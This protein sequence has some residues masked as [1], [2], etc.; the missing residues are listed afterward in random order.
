MFKA[1]DFRSIFGKVTHK[2]PAFRHSRLASNERVAGAS[3]GKLKFRASLC[4]HCNNALTQPHDRAWE[5]LSSVLRAHGPLR[6]GAALPL[7][8]AFGAGAMRSMLDVHLYFLKLLGCYAVE[9]NVPLPIPHFALCIRN[10]VAHPHIYL[11]FVAME[12][13][14][15]S[16]DA[17]VGNIQ[18]L[19]LGSRTVAASWF[20]LV[21]RLGVHVAYLEPGHPRFHEHRGWHPEQIGT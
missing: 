2:A 8:R 11:A 10:S 17:M 19:S 15:R 13:G 16:A 1:S 4:S 12:S 7:R 18:A 21:G 20:Y 9:Y 6:K 3:S 5:R 14:E